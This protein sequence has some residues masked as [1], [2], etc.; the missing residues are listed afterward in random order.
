MQV[1]DH[2]V[3]ASQTTTVSDSFNMPR[4]APAEAAASRVTNKGNPL[5]DRSIYL[6]DREKNKRQ[7]NDF[8]SAMGLGKGG[9]E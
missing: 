5:L 1:V 6:A 9:R 2:D 7:S 8:L 4:P 3:F